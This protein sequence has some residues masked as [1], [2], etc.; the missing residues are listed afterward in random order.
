MNISTFTGLSLIVFSLTACGTAGGDSDSNSSGT[1]QSD[2]ETYNAAHDAITDAGLVASAVA[3]GASAADARSDTVEM[4]GIYGIQSDDL[5]GT[6]AILG[7]MSMTANF[8]NDTVSG[9]MTNNFIAFGDTSGAH[10][11][12]SAEPLSGSMTYVG[13]VSG[14]GITSH[15]DGILTRVDGTQYDLYV[16]MTG[17]FYTVT[18]GTLTELGA[19]GNFGGN[20]TVVGDTSGKI[21]DLTDG[22]DFDSR[23][24][25]ETGFVVCESL[26]SGE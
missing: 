9:S 1:S 5:L 7:E 13:T 4:S 18:D 12:D 22:Y 8:G 25:N 14:D 15:F 23:S 24:G 19:I 16:D 10:T 11:E 21:Y 3:L 20:I 2:Y 6:D 26:C 17:T